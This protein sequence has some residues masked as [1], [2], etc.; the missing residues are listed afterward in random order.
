MPEAGQLALLKDLE[1][2]DEE[3]AAELAEVDEL[4]R[5]VEGLR[6]RAS[7]LRALLDGLPAE[8]EEAA[9]A[10][11]AAEAAAAEARV[12]RDQAVAELTGA[13]AAGAADRLASAR[14]FEVRARDH[15]T[16]AERRAEAARGHVADLVK[17]T[18]A[19]EHEAVE[20][21][22]R[23]R[24]LAAILARRPRLAD[25]TVADPGVGL[26]GVAEWGTQ[27]RA[28]LLVA[29]GQLAGERDAIVRQTA[30]L[31]SLLLR[32]SLPPTSAAGVARRVER[33]LGV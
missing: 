19:A 33:E 11:E 28:A 2:A 17:R 13:E 10:A 8:R 22:L 26:E 5:E 4:Q 29:R 18:G 21:E 1:R 7:E 3:V 23:A 31:G 6:Q 25:V 20:L 27:A 32:E 24:K 9:R 15:L 14:R 12:T 16:V 30:E